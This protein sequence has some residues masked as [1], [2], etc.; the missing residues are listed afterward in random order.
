MGK[1]PVVTLR[2]Y[3]G[4]KISFNEDGSIQNEN[5]TVKLEHDTKSWVNFMKNLIANGYGKVVVERIAIPDTKKDEDG[6]FVTTM[7]DVERPDIV[8]EVADAFKMPEQPLSAQEKRIKEL[9]DRLN[10]LLDAQTSAKSAKV[11]AKNE[12][13]D[14]KS[15]LVEQYIEKFGKKPFA[16]WDEAKLKEKIAE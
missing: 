5:Q 10:A 15:A 16:G 13:N 6:F 12:V 4:Q 9:E 3:R 8:K 11:E 7:T 2:V 1:K 14:D